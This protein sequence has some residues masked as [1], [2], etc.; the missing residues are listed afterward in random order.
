MNEGMETPE[1]RESRIQVK[2]PDFLEGLWAL[3]FFA[4]FALT[5]NCSFI[6]FDKDYVE[7]WSQKASD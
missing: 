7:M 4:L 3:L 1:P 2:L 5:G 6:G